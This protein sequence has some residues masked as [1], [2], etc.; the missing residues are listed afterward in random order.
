MTVSLGPQCVAAEK[1]A[2]H[3]KQQC[4]FVELNVFTGK[5][6]KPVPKL[7]PQSRALTQSALTGTAKCEKCKKRL[8]WL[9]LYRAL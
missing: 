1:R 5:T 2:N 8:L 9:W 6:L 4:F 7:F 3:S